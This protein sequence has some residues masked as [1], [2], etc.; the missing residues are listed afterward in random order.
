MLA[1]DEAVS[2]RKDALP[3]CLDGENSNRLVSLWD[4]LERYA[5]GFYEVV[6]HLENQHAKIMSSSSRP[7]TVDASLRQALS[8]SLSEMRKECDALALEHTSGLISHHEAQIL[9][10]GEAYTYHEMLSDLDTLR[11]SFSAELRKRVFLRIREENEKYF[12]KDD[13]FG[14]AVNTAFPSCI[15]EIRDAGN[16]YALEQGEAA[17]Y[18]LMRVLE[19]GLRTLAVKFGVDFSHTNW[20]N[21]IEAVEK[22]IRKMNSSLGPDWKEQQKFCSQAA[23]H[24]MFLK[25]AWRNHVM[26]VSDVPYD[27]GRALSVLGHVK[28]FMQ[29]LA[30]GGIKE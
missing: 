16:C 9:R 5:F 19:R 28:D 10:K 24:F 14:I 29:A 21:V 25:D 18:H 11:F 12:Q 22:E 1:I 20:H 30:E 27:Q 3:A 23:T 6:C 26:H 2:S 4:M 13:L 8:K 17:V 7:T 15:T